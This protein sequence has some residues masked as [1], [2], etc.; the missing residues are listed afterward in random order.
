MA[1]KSEEYKRLKFRPTE[2]TTQNEEPKKLKYNAL[3]EGQ[4]HYLSAIDN[5]DIVFCLGMPGSG[6]TFL[7]V[8]KGLELL[9]SSKIDQIIITRPHVEAGESLGYLPGDKD[10][11]SGPFSKPIFMN[12]LKLINKDTLAKYKHEN[13]I[14]IE[15]LAYMRG[16][17][18]D[19]AFMILD[20]A[21]NA[22]VEQIELFLT[23]IGQGSKAIVCGDPQQ[24]DIRHSGLL[25]CMEALKGMSSF[26]TVK[27]TGKDVV[28]HRL[29]G[30]IVKRLE[31]AKHKLW[32]L[33][34]IEY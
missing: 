21:Q 2:H 1:K 5:N 22:S 9:K 12:M 17:T 18:Y 13:M 20:E 14:S 26:Q 34:S 4:E 31:V 16:C 33:T 8:A 6:K 23:R 28:R 3:S 27:L 11:K 30:E 25:P 10:E 19:K 32:G 15:P 29:I 7:A 24:Y